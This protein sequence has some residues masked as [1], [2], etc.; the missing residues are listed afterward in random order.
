MK[1]TTLIFALLS[2]VLLSACDNKPAA[3]NVLQQLPDNNT[4]VSEPATPNA[5]SAV[6]RQLPEKNNSIKE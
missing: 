3:S 2:A 6:L 4:S 1:T 5:G